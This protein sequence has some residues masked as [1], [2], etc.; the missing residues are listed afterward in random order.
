MEVL[1]SA[2]SLAAARWRFWGSTTAFSRRSAA[3]ARR[4]FGASSSLEVKRRAAEDLG[5][6]GA[7]S[8]RGASP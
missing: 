6:S 3:P 5:P 2:I 7:C 1:G 8:S 4:S